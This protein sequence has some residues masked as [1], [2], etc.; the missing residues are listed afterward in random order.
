M[1]NGFADLTKH[2]RFIALISFMLILT[3]C[4]SSLRTE[5]VASVTHIQALPDKMLDFD[6]AELTPEQIYWQDQINQF[7][8]ADLRTV[9]IPHV[10][11][12][13]E[14][15]NW[16]EEQ[17][18]TDTHMEKIQQAIEL[19]RT[20]LL[21]YSLNAHCGQRLGD[22]ELSEQSQKALF[23]IADLLMRSGNAQSPS[24]AVKTRD[25]YEAQIIFQ[26]AGYNVFDVELL[27]LADKALFRIH[28][29]MPDTGQYVVFYADNTEYF[30]RNIHS[31]AT[32][33]YSKQQ[34]ADYLVAALLNGGSVPAQ[35]LQFSDWLR[36]NKADEVIERL[37]TSSDLGPLASVL[38]SQA[39]F[40]KSETK[41]FEQQIDNLLM[42]SEIGFVEASAILG[43]SMLSSDDVMEQ[44][45]AANLFRVNVRQ[46]GGSEATWIW[47]DAL[48]KQTDG[49]DTFLILINQLEPSYYANWRNSIYRY[50][51]VFGG[52]SNTIYSKLQ[53]LLVALGESYPRARLDYAYLNISGRWGIPKDID[54]GLALVKSLAES[55]YDSAQLDYGLF[56][57]A[58]RYGIEQDRTKAFYWYQKAAEQ[59]NR[60]ALYNLGLAY[61]YS[62]GV[63]KDLVMSIEYFQQ[64]WEKGFD[65]AGCRIGDI[66]SEEIDV[67]NYELAVQAYQA[68][69]NAEDSDAEAIK[70]CTF[71]LGYVQFHE[72][73]NYQ[74]GLKMLDMAADLGDQNAM[75]ELGIIYT[76]NKGVEANADKA[77]TYYQRAIEQGSGRAAANLGYL[78]ESGEGVTKDNAKALHYY[79]LSSDRGSATGQNNYASFL[80][81]GTNVEKDPQAAYKL[82]L[83]SYAQGNTYA[84][85]NLGDMYYF[86][87][88]GEPDYEK[89]CHFYEQ[90]VTRGATDALYDLAYCFVYGEGREQDV[91]KGLKLLERSVQV[92]N[93]E[94]MVELGYLYSDG[95]L[96]ER[97]VPLAL[98]YL[99]RAY[100]L[101]SPRAAYQLG[102]LYETGE[103]VREDAVLAKVYYEQ[104]AQWGYIDGMIA[105]A[106]AYIKGLGTRTNKSLAR[107]WLKKAI[108]EGSEEAKNVLNSL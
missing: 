12:I 8:R 80:R 23:A 102:Q 56:Y 44:Q 9:K 65:L 38:L 93:P 106:N 26:W 19:N 105:L 83:K 37:S 42:F 39:Y 10:R 58:G 55:G 99:K 91:E 54:K 17:Y 86:G 25:A 52:V 46:L 49:V 61:R 70:A 21:A 33:S 60:S 96:V 13:N 40:Q 30:S 1:Y 27:R 14:L 79:K 50:D 36:N 71:G 107:D 75:F 78:Y 28:A 2:W 43:V 66:Y 16:P 29:L 76:D 85:E 68:T 103:G 53:R 104:S 74:A 48:L 59:G 87:E 4:A 108:S 95:E 98:D 35:L 15:D 82:Y 64:A 100:K 7:Y 63:E 94:A 41:K 81:Y 34:I 84:A 62:R 3:G 97:N 31:M 73:E 88:L 72:L 101:Q 11:L 24:T 90:A 6:P 18:C 69:I 5:N 92:D 57:S 77:I 22:D 32:K 47:L 45:D 20:S 67:L 51:N 89:A